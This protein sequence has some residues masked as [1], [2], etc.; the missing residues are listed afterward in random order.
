MMTMQEAFDKAYN[1]VVSQGRKSLGPSGCQM[2]SPD[3]ERCSIGHLLTNEQINTH[4]LNN[5]DALRVHMRLGQIVEGH[6]SFRFLYLLQAAH[7]QSG[8]YFDFVRDFK[9]RMALVATEF[10]LKVPT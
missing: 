2:Y 3:G 8:S 10:N 4:Q 1:G 5:A 6:D 7:D 9:D